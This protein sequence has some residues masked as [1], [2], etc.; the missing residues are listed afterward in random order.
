MSFLLKIQ[1]FGFL[2]NR[3]FSQSG[4]S[5]LLDNKDSSYYMMYLGILCLHSTYI[6]FRYQ[7]SFKIMFIDFFIKHTFY[8]R[9]DMCGRPQT[10][11]VYF[12]IFCLKPFCFLSICRLYQYVH[13]TNI[14]NIKNQL[15]AGCW[16]NSLTKY[17]TKYL[18]EKIPMEQLDIHSIEHVEQNG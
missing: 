3:R 14:F 9:T 2:Y 16:K 17:S 10:R 11:M 8:R 18:S 7:I 1:M 13:W 15:F 12:E 6:S 4:G 5:A